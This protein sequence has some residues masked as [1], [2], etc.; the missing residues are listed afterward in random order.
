MKDK[1]KTISEIKT[2]INAKKKEVD[3]PYFVGG[4]LEQ[5]QNSIQ[6]IYLKLEEIMERIE[7]NDKL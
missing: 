4:S 1:I 6:D 2:A 3:K 7:E 5:L